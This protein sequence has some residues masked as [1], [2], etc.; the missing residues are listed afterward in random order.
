MKL[1]PELPP[2]AERGT[3]RRFPFSRNPRGISALSCHS[4]PSRTS[5]GADPRLWRICGPPPHALVV[6]AAPRPRELPP[7]G[8][9][10]GRGPGPP[11]GRPWQTVADFSGLIPLPAAARPCRFPLPKCFAGYHLWAAAAAAWRT[12]TAARCRPLPTTRPSASSI[13]ICGDCGCSPNAAAGPLSH[14]GRLLAGSGPKTPGFAPAAGAAGD[15][16]R[17]GLACPANSCPRTTTAPAGLLGPPQTADTARPLPRASRPGRA[18]AS[19]AP[20][21]ASDT[22]IIRSSCLPGSAPIFPRSRGRRVGNA[23]GAPCAA[24]S[25]KLLGHLNEDHRL[26]AFGSRDSQKTALR[27]EEK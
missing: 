17:V 24:G 15:H 2:D 7:A 25:A 14:C 12:P 5:P 10:R 21:F 8:P 3:S 22:A 4:V 13:T 20:T 26:P 11:I 16:S 23:I 6:S 9:S 1:P 19:I 27:S 18:Q